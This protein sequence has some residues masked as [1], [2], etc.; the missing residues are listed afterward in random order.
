MTRV[1]CGRGRGVGERFTGHQIMSGLRGHC[2]ALGLALN[3]MRRR[4]VVVSNC[5]EHRLQKDGEGQRQKQGDQFESDCSDALTSGP[6]CP[7]A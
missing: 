5:V 3:E 1:E 6:T 7:T 4:E 2:Q